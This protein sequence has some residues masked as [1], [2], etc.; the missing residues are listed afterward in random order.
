MFKSSLIFLSIIVIFG[1]SVAALPLSAPS[2]FVFAKDCCENA[3]CTSLPGHEC[4]C[5]ESAPGCNLGTGKGVGVCGP[6]G[7]V[8]LCP[9][10]RWHTL[11]DLAES[12]SNW[13]FSVGLILVPLM[14]V[15]AG[16]MYATSEGD[17]EKVKKG[18]DMLFWTIIGLVVMLFSKIFISVI[19]FVLGT[20]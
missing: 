6:A 7:N 18:K 5:E 14:I 1:F 9:P 11:E 3:D 16:F 12:I 2:G 10:T 20:T 4:H 15:I 17:K 8:V 13:L 19:R